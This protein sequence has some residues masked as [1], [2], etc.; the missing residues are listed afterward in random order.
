L[1]EGPASE[2][3]RG[4]EEANAQDFSHVFLIHIT[5]IA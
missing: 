1:S 2:R 3:Q 4:E 5:L